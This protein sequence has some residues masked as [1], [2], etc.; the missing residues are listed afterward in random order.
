MTVISFPSKAAALPSDSADFDIT[1][2]WRMATVA[3]IGKTIGAARVATKGD[4]I[5]TAR[6]D[7][8]ESDLEDFLGGNEMGS[9]FELIQLS[10]R[11][12]CLR[13]G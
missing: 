13:H 2:V 10:S 12:S 8:L 6:I 5:A 3:S 7:K 1:G 4:P 11:A 9:N